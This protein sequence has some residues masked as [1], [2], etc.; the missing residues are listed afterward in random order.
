MSTLPPQRTQFAWPPPPPMPPQ[1]PRR[2]WP[3]IAAAAA[4]G[5]LL[6]GVITTAI[7]LH[8][9]TPAPAPAAQ[10][11]TVTAAPPAPPAPLPA[12]VADA[13]TCKAWQATNDIV[14]QA[15][16][17]QSV[18]P[19]GITIIDPAVQAHPDWAGAVIHSADLLDQAANTLVIAPG[20]STV[21]ADIATTTVSSLRTLATA[22]RTFD[23][24]SGNALATFQKNQDAITVVCQT[25]K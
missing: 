8:A 25:H 12:A 15:A 11:T 4:V 2:R 14:T 7:T 10:T 23:E 20:T 5:A 21:L 22:D 19:K 3:L 17:A 16:Q 6:A 24:A 18:I 13:K 9:T 1:G